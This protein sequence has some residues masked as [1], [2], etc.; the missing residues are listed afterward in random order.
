MRLLKPQ[1]IVVLL[2]MALSPPRS[3]HF[4]QLSLVLQLGMAP[5][6][7][8][9]ILQTC[10]QV[11]LIDEESK[12]INKANLTEF[13]IHGLKYAFPA[14]LGPPCIAIK[15]RIETRYKGRDELSMA[16]RPHCSRR[17]ART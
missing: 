17:H 8:S 9:R 2:K 4:S 13:V 7:I 1:D 16:S 3:D 11:R 6:A 12:K 10:Y 5:S 15:N 14:K